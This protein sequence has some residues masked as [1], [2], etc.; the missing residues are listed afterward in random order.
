MIG[1]QL[2]NATIRVRRIHCVS[3]PAVQIPDADTDPC[4]G[5]IGRKCRFKPAN[6]LACLTCR[7]L[8]ALDCILGEDRQLHRIRIFHRYQGN[9]RIN[10]TLSGVETRE[11]VHPIGTGF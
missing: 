4:I 11:C 3:L 10:I 6:Q 9:C 7:E 5:T 1:V 2:Q 8:L